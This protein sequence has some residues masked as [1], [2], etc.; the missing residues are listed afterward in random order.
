MRLF[1]DHIFVQPKFVSV[2]HFHVFVGTLIG[3]SYYLV[4]IESVLELGAI[5]FFIHQASKWVSFSVQLQK[6]Q[7]A[8]RYPKKFKNE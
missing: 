1:G 5:H 8:C 6:Y 2:S 7:H 4:A 3:R